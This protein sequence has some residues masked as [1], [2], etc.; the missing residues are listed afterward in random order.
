MAKKKNK[1]LL[2]KLGG[3]ALAAVLLVTAT[4]LVTL[5]PPEEAKHGA[6]SVFLN[7]GTCTG[8]PFYGDYADGICYLGN[9]VIDK[10]VTINSTINI[11]GGIFKPAA[12][13]TDT[14]AV[15]IQY[16]AANTSFTNSVIDGSLNPGI[17]QLLRAN[18]VNN[19]TLDG[20][21]F[22][23]PGATAI[24]GSYNNGWD[25]RYT[26]INDA[27]LGIFVTSM[28]SN[29]SILNTQLNNVANGI[30]LGGG[31]SV[32]VKDVT[33]TGTGTGYGIMTRFAATGRQIIDSSFTGF[34]KGIDIESDATTGNYFNNNSFCDSTQYDVYV[35]TGAGIDVAQDAAFNLGDT[36]YNPGGYYLGLI[37]PCAAPQEFEIRQDNLPFEAKELGDYYFAES[38]SDANPLPAIVFKNTADGSTLDMRSFSA[39]NTDGTA[40]KLEG[41]VSI[42]NGEVKDSETAIELT[43]EADNS[44]IENVKFD[45]NTKYLKVNGT[46]DGL[47]FVKNSVSELEKADLGSGTLKIPQFTRG[48]EVGNDFKGGDLQ[49][50]ELMGTLERVYDFD[51][52]NQLDTVPKPDSVYIS[53]QFVDIAGEVKTLNSLA[54]IKIDKTLKDARVKMSVARNVDMFSALMDQTVAAKEMLMEIGD[55][56]LSYADMDHDTP[57]LV[58]SSSDDRGHAWLKEIATSSTAP[59]QKLHLTTAPF[60]D[61]FV[62]TA[63]SEGT[64][65]GNGVVAKD[66][67]EKLLTTTFTL[68]AGDNTV[69]CDGVM[70]TTTDTDCAT[71]EFGT[72]NDA[73]TV[74]SYM[75]EASKAAQSHLKE[76]AIEDVNVDAL[77]VDSTDGSLEGPE[78][79]EYT[80]KELVGYGDILAPNFLKE[81][82]MSVEKNGDKVTLKVFGDEL[83]TFDD[84]EFG[85]V[86][87]KLA[88][89]YSVVPYNDGYNIASPMTYRKTVV[90]DTGLNFTPSAQSD[91]EAYRLPSISK[92]ISDVDF[93]A[94]SR[95]LNHRNKEAISALGT[96]VEQAKPLSLDRSA[97]ILASGGDLLVE[98]SNFDTYKDSTAIPQY[99]KDEIALSSKLHGDKGSVAVAYG[100]STVDKYNVKLSKNNV[101]NYQGGFAVSNARTDIWDNV[102]ELKT[103][104][105][106][107]DRADLLASTDYIAQNDLPT[108]AGVDVLRTDGQ[109]PGYT[110]SNAGIVVNTG[111]DKDYYAANLLDSVYD[112][113]GNVIK[114]DIEGLELD[115]GYA[116]SILRNTI[117][118]EGG[119]GIAIGGEVD[120]SSSI[121]TEASFDA[122][123]DAA[124]LIDNKIAAVVDGNTVKPTGKIPEKS[125]NNAAPVLAKV[126]DGADTCF[127]SVWPGLEEYGID[128][129]LVAATEE[130]VDGELVELYDVARTYISN[131]NCDKSGAVVIGGSAVQRL[132]QVVNSDPQY[133]AFVLGV[134]PQNMVKR[135][136]SEHVIDNVGK[137]YAGAISLDDVTATG[138]GQLAYTITDSQIAD[139]N[140]QDGIDSTKG[141]DNAVA[142]ALDN[143]STLDKSY[144]IVKNSVLD[145]VSKDV[146]GLEEVAGTVENTQY[147][148]TDNNVDNLGAETPF[149]VVNDEVYFADAVDAAA[150]N[151]NPEEGVKYT[152]KVKHAGQLTHGPATGV[153]VSAMDAS[154]T[155]NYSGWDIRGM[156]DNCS[157]DS[158]TT[159]VSTDDKWAEYELSVPTGMAIMQAVEDLENTNSYGEYLLAKGEVNYL[160]PLYTDLT[161]L[162][163]LVVTQHNMKSKGHR[164]SNLWVFE[165]L[166]VIWEGTTE[167]YP[168]VFESDSDWT[169]D[170]CVSVPEGYE[171]VAPE[172][173]VQTFVA[174]E[175]KNIDFVVQEVGT[176]NTDT[177]VDWSFTNP[178]GKTKKE[179]SKIQN[180]IGKKY[181]EQFLLENGGD[182]ED[183]GYYLDTSKGEEGKLKKLKKEKKN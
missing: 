96:L 161:E 35:E 45:S 18:S 25:I 113:N 102:L 86:P 136:A 11:D 94:L 160:E 17:N 153:R 39:T 101:Y 128:P 156:I 27:G 155:S 111:G 122:A 50:K 62:N 162:Q 135:A 89:S 83:P 171:I 178:A 10:T 58:A 1:N 112:A 24:Y 181:V 175:I 103:L 16:A 100:N 33:A 7:S 37:K 2:M 129:N 9:N 179:K 114:A 110:M 29:M 76:K 81:A 79:F 109:N 93:V 51:A 55:N 4:V 5:S 41:E 8:A 164:G 159:V 167:I 131:L 28:G 166:E 64:G 6:A 154:C 123:V 157:V 67:L 108:S 126:A 163:P 54:K 169:V 44:S 130:T 168:F 143:Y 56:G 12:T 74:K 146:S 115:R 98:K 132:K 144:Y 70:V 125:A 65:A 80:S 99:A 152:A 73:G 21:T 14:I 19:L 105:V 106:H 116:T 13:E 149:E 120:S 90:S 174:N 46:I 34:Q 38:V 22:N 48:L 32:Q 173:C 121:C 71:V 42:K 87:A 36:T 177:D 88:L 141:F 78:N 151:T 23:A 3:A 145:N 148:L 69:W 57:V 172:A 91:I 43:E 68:A 124:C 95:N 26:T 147:I 133:D 85:G 63:V 61:G 134:S 180:R 119:V 97:G 138:E 176:V 183:L 117:S 59:L 104:G 20:V 31:N 15:S 60:V 170:V 165:P 72:F 107:E 118:L 127:V 84:S 30:F 140:G 142:I 47:S 150:D 77:D 158:S 75:I 182:L 139:S 66:N 82:K 92:T 137:H 49:A 52:D 53:D 40:I